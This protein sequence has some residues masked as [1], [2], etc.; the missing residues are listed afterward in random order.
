MENL[1]FI[2]KE[3][4]VMFDEEGIYFPIKYQLSDS[5]SRLEESSMEATLLS[6]SLL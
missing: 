6:I 5:N 4:V 1:K 2:L 3:N